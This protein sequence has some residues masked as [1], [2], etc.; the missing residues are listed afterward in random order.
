M[1]IFPTF[2]ATISMGVFLIGIGINILN[3]YVKLYFKSNFSLL[4]VE[5]FHNL[6]NK[7]MKNIFFLEIE[8]N[9]A[10]KKLFEANF[11]CNE[12]SA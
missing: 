1:I 10:T 9:K 2:G 8:M 4:V 3:F 5:I 12:T 6:K 7:K 11:Q